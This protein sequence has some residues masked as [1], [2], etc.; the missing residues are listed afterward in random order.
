[1]TKDGLLKSI[2][3]TGYNVGFGAKKHFATY[4]IV[5]KAP[6]WIGFISLAVGIL[7]LVF[8]GLSAKLPSACLTIA[9]VVA[10]YIA[11]Y[12]R[13]KGKYERAGKEM[14][15]LF[16][17]LRDLYRQVQAD[18]DL[19][20]SAGSLG[21]IEGR[22]YEVAISKQILFSDWYAHYK[23]FAQHQIEWIDEQKHFTWRDQVP[24]SF[25]ACLIAVA[26]L[27]VSA[28]VVAGISYW[29]A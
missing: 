19:K 17:Q 3:E 25:R 16:N 14:T 27:V 10:L 24:L 22:F 18:A 20:V 4:D 29:R 21:L 2:A 15:Q 26:F 5:E 28:V 7:S 12:D 8:E 1:M 11:F 9:G 6:G 23:F 13:D